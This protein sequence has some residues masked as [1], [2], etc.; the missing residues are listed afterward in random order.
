MASPF[1]VP[2]FR[3]WMGLRLFSTT[4]SQIQLAAIG[5]AVYIATGDPLDLAWVGLAQFLPVLLLALPAGQ[6]ADRYDRRFILGTCYFFQALVSL[7]FRPV[8]QT[9]K[10]RRNALAAI[11][12][13]TTPNPSSLMIP[14]T[15]AILHR[16][17][18]RGARTL[19]RCEIWTSKTSTCK[20]ASC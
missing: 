16:Q 15:M 7:A 10:M 3:R 20:I 14:T 6:V 11:R 13:L 2:A 17:T 1:A 8:S 5:W 9:R 19:G 4:A 18:S 12:K